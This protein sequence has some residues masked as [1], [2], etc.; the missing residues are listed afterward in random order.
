MKISRNRIRMASAQGDGLAHGQNPRECI[1][2]IRRMLYSRAG[3]VGSLFQQPSMDV[4]TK[5]RESLSLMYYQ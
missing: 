4:V 5:I 2:T 1:V 3:V